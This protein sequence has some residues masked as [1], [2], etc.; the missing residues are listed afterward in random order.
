MSRRLNVST[1]LEWCG[2]IAMAIGF[3]ASGWGES[4]GSL[5]SP[6]VS[7]NALML[8]QNS[9][10]HRE[11]LDPAQLD[12]NPNGMGL[13]EA[14][15]Q[16][17]ADVDPYSKLNLV[18][19]VHPELTTDGTSISESWVVEPE[20][21]FVESLQLPTVNLRIG[22]QKASFGKH[23]LLHTHTFPF[24]KAHLA[25]SALLGD[26]GL[27]D[28]GVSASFLLPPTWFSE[29]TLEYYRGKGENDE[30]NSPSPG[31]GVGLGHFRNLFDYE[32]LTFEAGFS[33]ASGANQ[34]HGTTRLVGVDMTWKW[35]P[36]AMGRY[37][38][39]L[40]NFEL[41]DRSMSQAAGPTES[42]RGWALWM[43]TQTGERTYVS[44]RFDTLRLNQAINFVEWPDGVTSRHSIGYTWKATEFSSIRAEFS[45]RRGG[46]LGPHG[47][48]VEDVWYLQAN[49]TIG[50]HPS[51]SY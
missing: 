9:S 31:Q 8:Y 43:Q 29:L 6:N 48:Q 10:V 37:R 5:K 18:L 12:E 4:V 14:E 41:I 50:A 3:S 30:F 46:K 21:L 15:L 33:Y 25:Q 39:L 1:L 47:E 49:F 28:V 11:D 7:A 51:H 32:D 34:Y 26:E 27:N 36:H 17:Y 22:K 19:S 44:Y 38:S 45:E 23:N 24:V 13:R 16:F 35:R 20:E 42:G 40:A 2:I